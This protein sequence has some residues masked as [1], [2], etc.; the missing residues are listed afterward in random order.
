MLEHFVRHLD[1]GQRFLR[2]LFAFGGKRSDNL[3]RVADFII[4]EILIDGDGPGL[5]IAPRAPQILPKSI[6]HSSLL[7]EVSSRKRLRSLSASLTALASA[8]GMAI[9][10]GA[11]ASSNS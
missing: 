11:L 7:T 8:S 5:C 6:A 9:F 3:S 4:D 10:A 2:N 1:L